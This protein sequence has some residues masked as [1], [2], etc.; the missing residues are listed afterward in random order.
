MYSY[1][2]DA[3]DTTGNHSAQSA[4]LPVTTPAAAPPSVP[5]A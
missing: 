4:A 5:A 1:T 2:V 3:F